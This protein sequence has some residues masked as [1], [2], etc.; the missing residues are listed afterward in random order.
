MVRRKLPPLKVFDAPVVQTPLRGLL[1]NMDR[2]L[3]RRLERAKQ[4]PDREQERRL[5]LLMMMMRFT[6]NS[7]DAVSFLLTTEGDDPKRKSRFALVVP[8]INRQILDLLFSLVF[9]LDDFP[10]RSL[11][12]ELSGYRQ[13]REEYDKFHRRYGTNPKWQQ[14]FSDLRDLQGV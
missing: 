3:E 1:I 12:Y 11:A 6:G 10:E 13:I 9:M 14:Y 7:Y 5:S 4:S 8:P 2:D